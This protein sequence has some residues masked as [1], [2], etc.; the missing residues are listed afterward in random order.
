ML[1]EAAIKHEKPIESVDPDKII[2]D[3]EGEYPRRIIIRDKGG[4]RKEYRLVKTR[5][6]GF[7]LNR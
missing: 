7:I 2:L 6:G 5:S 4:L 1:N 3:A